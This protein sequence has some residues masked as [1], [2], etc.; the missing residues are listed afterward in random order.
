MKY[1]HKKQVNY[2]FSEAIDRTKKELKIHGFG[3]LTQIDIKEKLKEKLNA[4]YNNYIILGACNPP[5]AY[6]ALLAEK[7]IG[8]LLPCNVVV[9]EDDGN[10]FVLA[11]KPTVAMEMIESLELKKIAEQIEDKLKTVIDNV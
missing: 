10:V 9:Y 4:D 5:F 8:L 3:V 2:S 7:D 11:I 1:G 6:K